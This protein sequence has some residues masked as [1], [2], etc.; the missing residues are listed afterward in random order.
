VL[1]SKFYSAEQVEAIVK[2]YR[3]AGLSKE[4]V[5]L[6]DF[7]IKLTDHAYKITPRDIDRLHGLG[8]SDEEIVDV[9]AT[10]AQRNF[11]SKLV[12]ALGGEPEESFRR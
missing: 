3:T 12:D 7:A 10:A 9:A 6:I 4:E 2:D 5:A 8:V 11:F 1:R